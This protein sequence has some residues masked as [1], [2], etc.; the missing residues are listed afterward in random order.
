MQIPHSD[1]YLR[2]IL[3][4]WSP[5]YQYA[6][7]CT[8]TSIP[9]IYVIALTHPWQ[10][11]RLSI[12][13][14]FGSLGQKVIVLFDFD[15]CWLFWLIFWL[16]RESGTSRL[17]SFSTFFPKTWVNFQFAANFHF[18][19]LGRISHFL[20]LG[21]ISHI[22][23]LGQ[24]SHFLCFGWISHSF[25]ALWFTDKHSH[26]AGMQALSVMRN[27]LRDASFATS[28]TKRARKCFGTTGGWQ[29][30]V[31]RTLH[32]HSRVAKCEFLHRQTFKF[33]ISPPKHIICDWISLICFR[34]KTR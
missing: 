7:V 34:D 23:Y 30:G 26:C 17:P 16:N 32:L 27:T 11:C 4:L 22:F 9:D 8:I 12:W 19:P 31:R 33:K 25:E 29:V 24:T 15:K 21:R 1:P 5:Y 20:R 18:L 28:N 14:H 2:K 13:S 10:H 3:P 6:C